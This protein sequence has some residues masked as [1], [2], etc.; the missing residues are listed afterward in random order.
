MEFL[1]RILYPISPGP[2]FVYFP[3]S[4]LLYFVAF[5]AAL[6][7]IL[8]YLKKSL[9]PISWNYKHKTKVYRGFLFTVISWSILCLIIGRLDILDSSTSSIS[10]IP[11]VIIIPLVFILWLAR[12]PKVKQLLDESPD[13]TLINANMFRLFIEPVTYMLFIEDYL[14]LEMTIQ[15]WNLELMVAFSAPLMIAM[16]F[17]DDIK[18]Y[19]IAIIWNIFGLLSLT[20]FTYMALSLPQLPEGAFVFKNQNLIMA[21]FPFILYP[22]LYVPLAFMLHTF[23]IRQLLRDKKHPI[24]YDT[25]YLHPF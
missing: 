1:D 6:L 12:T 23:S 11:I 18:R 13:A 2:G 3:Y 14:P 24:K 19:N 4:L 5:T 25:S 17:N 9:I 7:F 8:R 22:A 15:G 16:F 21:S 10:Y 20:V